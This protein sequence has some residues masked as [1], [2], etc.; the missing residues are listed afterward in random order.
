VAY[1]GLLER[2]LIFGNSGYVSAEL[3]EILEREHDAFAEA[4]CLMEE[5]EADGAHRGD[6]ET[7]CRSVLAKATDHLERDHRTIYGAL[8]RLADC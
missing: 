2:A 6:L 5:L 4:L 1:H 8:A 7:L 3:R